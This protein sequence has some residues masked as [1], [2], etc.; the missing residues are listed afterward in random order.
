VAG[1]VARPVASTVHDMRPAVQRH[2]TRLVA[3]GL[4]PPGTLFDVATEAGQA[5]AACVRSVACHPC[6][7]NRVR[8]GG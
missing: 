8:D 6:Q 7:G 5:N 3:D 2:Y 4:A 1:G